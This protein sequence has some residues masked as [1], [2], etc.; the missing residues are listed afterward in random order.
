[1]L[2]KAIHQFHSGSAFG[3]AV[4]NGML[5]TRDLLRR[6]GFH[7][8]IYVQHLAPEL[9]QEIKSYRDYKSR[10]D[11]VLFVHHSI[12]HDLLDWIIGLRDIKILVYHNITPSKYFIEGSQSHHYSRIG[13]EQLLILKKHVAGSICDSQYNCE[14]LI[15]FGYAD[16]QSIPLLINADS[17]KSHQFNNE[18]VNDNQSHYNILFV[19]RLAANKCHH[20]ILDMAR[21]LREICSLDWK[22]FFVGGYEID[23]YYRFIVDK[24]S[25]YQLHEEVQLVGKV[26]DDDLYA[27]FRSA[28][29]YVSMSEHEGFGV[30]LVESMI[31]DVPVVAYDCCS[32]PET[33]NGGGLLFNNKDFKEIACIVKYVLE[34]KSLRR[35][36][37]RRQ[38][39]AL[40]RYACDHICQQLIGFLR[41][42][43][44]EVRG[45]CLSPSPDRVIQYQ[46]EGPFDSS[47]SLALVNREMALAQE[48]VAPGSVALFS[49]EGPGDFDPNRKFLAAHPEVRALWERSKQSSTVEV[50]ARNLFPPR[51]TGMSGV[52]RIMNAYGWEESEF[53]EQYV[54]SFN[55]YLDGLTVM[56]NYVK[57]VMIDNGVVVPVVVGGLGVDHLDRVKRTSCERHLGTGF[58]F[59]S[60]SSGFPRKGLDVL[61]SAY[62]RAFSRCD[63]VTLVIKTFP[64]VHNQIQEQIAEIKRLN[65]EIA[66]V[67][68]IN[69]D[70]DYGQLIDLYMQ[71]NAF[72]APSRGEGFGLPMAEA[73]YL[74]LP[75]ITT[76]YGGHA[77]FCSQDTAWLIDYRF[78]P[79]QTHMGL[80]DSVWVEPDV[81][82]LARLMREIVSLPQEIVRQKT[83][84]GKAHLVKHFT[85]DACVKRQNALIETLRDARPLSSKR[86]RVGWVS[87]WNVKCGIASYSRLL[88]DAMVTDRF[89]IF[90][91]ANRDDSLVAADDPSV[92]RCW[93]SECDD[94]VDL[95][96]TV[97]EL[98][99]DLL[100]IQFNFSLFS[101]NS[102]Q[103]FLRECSI[104]GIRCFITFHSTAD[105][106][107]GNIHKS[108]RSI[109]DQLKSV[110]RLFV[111][112]ANDC[113]ILK[114]FD[115]VD[116]VSMIP[117]GITR[118]NKH[119]IDDCKRIFG[120]GNKCIIATYGFM[121]PHKGINEI[122]MAFYELDNINTDIHLMLVNAL[123]PLPISHEIKRGCIDMIDRL[124]LN[125]K[126][127]IITDYL[128][129]DESIALLECADIIVFPYQITKESSS[130]AVRMGISTHRPVA[131]TP[132]DIFSDVK[133]VVHFLPGTTPLDI[134][135]GLAHILWNAD[136]LNSKTEKQEQWIATHSWQSIGLRFENM[137][138]SILQDGNAC[139]PDYKAV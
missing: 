100:V 84:A 34:D 125:D 58:R 33:L 137:M 69:K 108:I 55:K 110:D 77:D 105:V 103:S 32:I 18:I 35:A 136:L 12:G 5:F 70:L 99:I 63:E 98:S 60:I 45:E 52:Y 56:S 31:F 15:S 135:N 25:E 3:D 36:V 128:S 134:K 37:V 112:T 124:G 22:L 8:E 4:T 80:M 28:D 53:P 11:Q 118:R 27:Y 21:H 30:P 94:L 9:V 97:S 120:I 29:I 79:A 139:V 73:M 43:D 1:M 62:A 133:D 95:K 50:S 6:L 123:Y 23:E 129:D 127:T 49:T 16:V 65:V 54:R 51:V 81:Q 107:I 130:A 116:N 48:R 132:L 106:K 17:I 67:V 131:C 91:L 85:W 42:H 76:G 87:S 19:G 57:K 64:N 78:E 104:M 82:H 24:L 114:T 2:P 115:L 121:L 117:H 26:S 93:D 47:Y 111:H 68:L 13:R 109:R 75:V 89:D 92:V 44:I 59:L 138:E 90:V 102:L 38:R 122:I 113:N 126:V 88:L 86:W 119:K 74:G 83:E 7:S 71:C 46:Y 66:E 72:V 41:N 101:L 39:A 61:L 96:R 10:S 20:D 14:E 40:D